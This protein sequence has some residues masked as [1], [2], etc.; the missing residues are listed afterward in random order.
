MR[1]D[2][3]YSVSLAEKKQ[4]KTKNLLSLCPSITKKK[5]HVGH[6]EYWR[7]YQPHLGILSGSLHALTCKLA[8]FG[9][10]QESALEAVW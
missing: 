10:N 4:K 1:V 6:F 5:A 3:Q 9:P 7:Q 2:S 8:S